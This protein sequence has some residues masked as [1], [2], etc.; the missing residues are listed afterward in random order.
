MTNDDLREDLLL[1]A[2]IPE[3][4]LDC[5]NLCDCEEAMMKT[6]IN[7]FMSKLMPKIDISLN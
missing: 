1:S 6:T 5:D 7:V 2:Y 4:C 3:Q